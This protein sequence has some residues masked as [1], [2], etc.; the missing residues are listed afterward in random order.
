MDDQAILGNARTIRRHDLKGGPVSAI[1]PIASF[2]GI[3]SGG[4]GRPGIIQEDG[5]D[6]DVHDRLVG[7]IHDEA[8]DMDNVAVAGVADIHKL[9]VRPWGRNAR[10]R[11]SSASQSR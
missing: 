11:L 8:R 4:H 1:Q 7:I 3:F 5:L 6:A 10:R 2:N 9:Q